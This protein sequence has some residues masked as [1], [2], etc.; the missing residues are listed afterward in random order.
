MADK[1]KL[2]NNRDVA[3][4]F[5]TKHSW[6]GKF[7]RI[8]SI[9][10]MGVSTYNPSSMEATNQWL[11]ED[12]LGIVPAAR[13]GSPHEFTILV[14]KGKK[15]ETMRFSSEHRAE[16]ITEALRYRAGFGEPQ[17]ETFRCNG[18]KHHWSEQRVPVVLEAGP[19]SLDQ[20]H[21]ATGALVASYAYKDVEAVVPVSDYPG[22]FIVICGRF[23]R[24][25][26]FASEKRD[27]VLRL[28]VDKAARCVGVNVTSRK[29][30]VSLGYFTEHRLGHYSTDE[31]LTSLA[32][33]TVQKQSARHPDP[34]RR[35]LCLTETCL[36]ERDPA[37]YSVCT[38]R[39]LSHVFALVRHQE[40]AQTFSVEYNDGQVRSY[41]STDRD[42]LLASLLDSVRAAGNVDVH[43]RSTPTP[44]GHR[45]GPL[46]TPVEEE[47][48][49]M[50][51]KLLQ[52]QPPSWTAADAVARF[53]ANV[54]YSGLLHAV[55]GD[56]LFAENKERL[57]NAALTSLLQ[58][59]G[60]QGALPATVVEAQF[61][62]LRRLVASKAGFAAFTQLPGF[63]EQIGLKVVR[64]LKR[65][66][67]AIT[68]A[69]LDMLAALLQPMHADYDL[70]QEQL[71]K[72]SLLSSKVFLEK[73]LDVWSAHVRQGT[74]ALVVSAFLDFL[75]YGLCAPYSETTDGAQFDSLLELVAA[76]GRSLFKLFLHPSLAIVKGAGLV[77]RAIIGEGDA[78]T[79]ERM[80]DLA[81]AEGALPRH[82]HTALFTQSADGR[83][84]THRQLSRQ[85]ITLWCTGHQ[86]ATD[87]LARTVPPGLLAFLDSEESVPADDVERLNT[88]DN[89]QLATDQ[90][91]RPVNPHLRA[92]NQQIRN[93]EKFVEKHVEV[94][95]QHWR[96]RMGY[97]KTTEEKVRERPVVLR[98]RRERVKS[99]KNWRLFYYQFNRDHALPHLIWNF[100]TREELR[101]ALENEMRNFST[102]RDLGGSVDISWNHTEFEVQYHC[103][104]DEIQIGDYYLRLLLEQDEARQLDD[105][106]IRKSFE[107]FS[108]LYHRFL[109]TPKVAMKCMCLQAMAIVYGRHHEDIGHF[110]D[111]KY[112]VSMLE[113]C[114][115]R[116]ERD[117]LIL[118]ISK[119]IL[120]QRNVKDVLDAGGV[121]VLA[122]LVTLSHLHTSRA[123]VPT[124]SNVI[125]YGEADAESGEREWYFKPADGDRQDRQGPYTFKEMR[126]FWEDGTLS[127]RSRCWAQGMDG[128]RSLQAVPQLRWTLLATGQAVMNE[129]DMAVTI[130]NIFIT[131]CD[132]Y[133]SRD[134]DGAVIRPLPRVKRLLS[135]P[136][137][138]PHIVQ[139]LLTFDPILVEKVAT[140]LTAVVRDNPVAS[141]L[142][143]TGVYFFI[144]MY[145]GSNVQPIAKF[146]QLTHTSQAFRSEEQKGSD[147]MQ[148]SILGQLVPEAMVCYLHNYGAE[149][150]A[151][152]YLGEF[153]T[154]EVIWNNQMRKMMIGR[155]AAHLADF[156][157]RL[158]SN[159]R[160]IY[161]YCPM[162][163][164]VYPQLESELF[165]SIFYLRHLC[166]TSR[167]P[168]WPIGDPVALLK[169]VLLAWKREVE[170][171]PPSMSVD[172]ALG[173]LGLEP[174][175]SHDQN[176]VRKA[177]FRLAQKYH[178]DKN[179]DGRDKFE[180][181]NRAYEFLCSRSART[182]DGPDPHNI[183]LI[184]R[185]QSILFSRYGDELRPY[186]YAGYPMLVATIRMET[187]DDQLFSK[188]APLLSAAAEVAYYTVRCSALNA[189]ELRRERGLELLQSAY[190]RCCSVLS[191][192]SRPEDVAVQ[193]CSHVSR[194]YTVAAQFQQCR[195]KLIEMPQIIQDLCRVLY[196]KRLTHLC[197]IGV[198]CVSA[199]AADSI[200]Q[201]HMMQAGVLWHL[202]LFLFYYDFTLDEG[203]VEKSESSNQQEAANTLA[204][205]SL[206]ALARLAGYLTGDEETPPNKAID[207][208][209]MAMLTPYL[210]HLLRQYKMNE[211]LKLLNSNTESP[212]II[213]D[214]ST[215]TE[216]REFLKEQQTSKIRTGESDP[217]FGAEF[218]FSAHKDELVVGNIF[219]R[220]Y[221]QQPSFPLENPKGLAIDL[222]DFIGSLAQYLHSLQA[223]AASP[224]DT[225]DASGTKVKHAE[226]A[227][228]ALANVIQNNPGVEFQCIGHFSLLFGLL[229]L[230]GMTGVQQRAL[231]AIS[232][233]TGNQECVNDIAA[234]EVVTSL[235]LL[236]H[237]LPS[238]LLQSLDT[239]HALMSN[240]KIVKDSMSRGAVI[241]LLD[242]FCNAT[243]PDVRNKTAELLAKMLADKLVGP[244]VRLTL[245]RF[246][247]P[248]YMDAMRDSPESSV[249]MFESVQENPELI[250]N[251]EAR[252]KICDTVRRLKVAFYQK[253]RADPNATWKL[254]D[255]FAVQFT[256]VQGEVVVGGVFLRLFVANPGWVLRRPREF[257]TELLDTALSLMQQAPPGQPDVLEM[258]ATATVQLLHAQPALLDALPAQGHIPRL[259]KAMNGK[260]DGVLR[261][262]LM[263]VHQLADN[264]ACTKSIG[265][266]E[267]ISPLVHA[268]KAR[269]DMVGVACDTLYRLFS[270]DSEPL[271]QQALDAKLV[272]YLLTL[273]DGRLESDNPAAVKAQIVK[274]LKAMTR[275]LQH[276]EQ[277]SAILNRS[278]VWPEYRDQKH[279]LFI[280]ST[281]TAGYL[282]GGTP[283]VA[284]YLTAGTAKM[285]PDAPPDVD[286]EDSFNTSGGLL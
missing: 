244:K 101:E 257:L 61:H 38:L 161:Q 235:L 63:R 223:M 92:L 243:H 167:F 199:F 49:S 169:D 182:V 248:L 73:L 212:Y 164:V 225:S 159:T 68:H 172:D 52:Q 48:E 187:E 241:Y 136:S 125:E 29:E 245:L 271:V 26:L 139:L 121:K 66:C 87:L 178:P 210:V 119:L 240:T 27:T 62:A 7:R 198:E 137:C 249:H 25:H 37:S 207:A 51:L 246:L 40:S 20:R 96:T 260:N 202:L 28:M 86:T 226:M 273:L 280:T 230:E 95:L 217:N 143:L 194:C 2:K 151:Q 234:S 250:W 14:R 30:A 104:Q 261:A 22:G 251:D 286:H 236:L 5:L 124:Q 254:P 9:G 97:E 174:G 127:A 102:D 45:L 165:C 1:P 180:D 35:T 44:R 142:Y 39:P 99:E 196:Y 78:A 259:F 177:Y 112:I 279:D 255:N 163:H 36:L 3:C 58:R 88:R 74:G 171:K 12:F 84:L 13:G 278:Q 195:D 157:P 57:I 238:A 83:L 54:S 71:N 16:L 258:V 134:A 70:K 262:C 265:Q 263:I 232:C 155:I 135:E 10:T 183:V 133:P 285:M 218:R 252:E 41:L 188:A 203:G 65:D 90:A 117:R 176:H 33:F 115:D 85:L 256:N 81:L 205:K 219:V 138:L 106:P 94:A 43:V 209:L 224:A 166:D 82:L 200:L 46:F 150:F 247:P 215:R 160:A 228:E 272:Q 284:G 131:M 227:L 132:F 31:H 181:V 266:S 206:L 237:S 67:D 239:L 69:A 72:T 173:V 59:E 77:M 122:D 114:T 269:R 267:C 110:S 32:E 64:A 233:V 220:V 11:Y 275:S 108:D 168:D 185:T 79:A 6:K 8:F 116:A 149:K 107:F 93:A 120:N 264:E 158:R 123:Y 197:V 147:L 55:T 213:W 111:T 276:G 186:K 109:L 190:N 184:L 145:T 130:L 191:K 34:V 282:T 208:A 128:W 47:V 144:L 154:P 98:R 268:M 253:Q 75:T 242:L 80:Q 89:L 21:P 19:C 103:L 283:G 229:R 4:F 179:P 140:L 118:F 175:Q 100:K 153:D 281:T 201:L 113:R 76:R 270:R 50:H 193:V 152:I 222:L 126:G 53:N 42:S 148:R 277:V 24:M 192:S 60:D 204:K 18:F 156:S 189:E 146:L 17:E 211:V 91:G 162:P 15:S 170:K 23:G 105:S 216:L 214:N 274:A 141:K 221:N 231:N 56:S 129:T